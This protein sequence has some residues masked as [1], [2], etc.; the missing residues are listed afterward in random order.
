MEATG[1]ALAQ[2]L[3]LFRARQAD[4]LARGEAAG[5]RKHTSATLGLALALLGQ[6]APAAAGLMRLLAFL[7]PEPVPLGLLLAG[8]DAVEGLGAGAARVLEPLLGDPVAAGDAVTAL[9]R[10]SLAALAGNGLV[11]VHRL[12]QAITRAQLTAAE[13][14]Q[15]QQTA[16]AVVEAAV[17][18]EGAPPDAWPTYAVLLP[19]AR[20]VLDLTS[21]GTSRIARYLG[22]SGSYAAARDL[23]ALIADALGDSRDYGPEH[24]DTLGARSDHARWTGRSGDAA[25][26]RDQFAALLPIYERV[27]GPEHPDTLTTRSNL[28]YWTG[29][30]GDAAEARDQFAALLPIRARVLG[31][32]D[33]RTLTTRSN[34]ASWAVEAGDAA[35]ARDQFAALLPIY[36]RVLGPE[37]PRTLTTRSN[38]AAM[39]GRSGNVTGARDQFAALLP[40]FERVMG[41]DHPETLLMR[42]N[43]A[44]W[45]GRSG[46]AAGARDQFA[47]LLPIYERVLGSEHPDTLATRADLAHWTE[48]AK[49][50]G[51]DAS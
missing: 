2:Y 19:H 11:Q 28:A 40:I 38:V 16:A 1:T 13:A 34:L 3:P 6:D 46:N 36:E 23:F 47:A 15:W 41:A 43:L 39:T 14:D 20:A 8:N 22:N 26:A 18:A 12:V 35:E 42:A 9:R 21:D 51:P 10:Y 37:H 24:P 50:S 29:E 27:L 48:Q 45:T 32:E 30:A 25:E 31:P 44:I 7:A 33:P 4:L 5:H 49:T 17:P